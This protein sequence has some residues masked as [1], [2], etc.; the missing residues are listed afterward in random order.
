MSYSAYRY[1]KRK[2]I[3]DEKWNAC[4]E[5]NSDLPYGLSWY[6]D[7][8]TEE[9]HALVL[10]DYEAVF[11]LPIKKKLGINIIYNPF[12]CQQLGLFTDAS[13]PM[14]ESTCLRFLQRKFLYCNINLHYNSVAESS[15]LFKLRYN[16]ILPLNQ[17]YEK[18][19]ENFSKN[20]N[21]NITKYK[22]HKVFT[23]P[24][25]DANQFALFY[26]KNLSSQ[27]RGYSAKHTK[28]L[29]NLIRESVQRGMAEMIAAYTNPQ[30]PPVAMALFI[31][32]KNR[33]FNIAPIS[34]QQA[35]ETGAMTFI[36]DEMIRKY[37]NSDTIL[38]FEGSSVESIARFY[39]GF[40]AK[41]QNFWTYQH[42]F[43][44]TLLQPLRKNRG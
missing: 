16:Y 31:K 42:T 13:H 35:R 6:L 34:F 30:N 17:P 3:N 25:S 5:A 24:F 9:W 11:P 15:S 27:I 32:F 12:F 10:R 40:G 44:D 21:R 39:K 22:L 28:Y 23:R 4:I 20:T 43:F 36:I 7:S 26:E 8:V 29:E 38:D 2:H 37:A 14:F 18:I 33:I 19:R 41:Q 1:L